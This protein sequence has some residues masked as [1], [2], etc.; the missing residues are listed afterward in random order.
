[1]RVVVGG[2]FRNAIK[3]VAT[4]QARRATAMTAETP[5]HQ[6]A[7]PERLML[8]AMFNGMPPSG[9]PAARNLNA[10]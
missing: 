2:A 8:P 3:M 4:R 6:E 1:M 9:S 5:R 10:E 7:Q